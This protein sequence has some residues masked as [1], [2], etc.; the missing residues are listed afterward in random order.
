MSFFNLPIQLLSKE[1]FHSTPIFFDISY[2]C[3][4]YKCRTIYK[5]FLKYSS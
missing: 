4:Y 1:H 3:M 5:L 2:A